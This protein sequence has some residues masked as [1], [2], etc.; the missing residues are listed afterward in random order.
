MNVTMRTRRAMAAALL[1]GA[2]LAAAT[3]PALAADSGQGASGHPVAELFTQ[4]GGPLV[5]CAVDDGFKDCSPMKL[6]P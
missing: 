2:G 1:A 4:V 5:E 6:N 3:G